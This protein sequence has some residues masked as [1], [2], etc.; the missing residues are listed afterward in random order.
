MPDYEILR[1]TA[2]LESLRDRWKSLWLDDPHATPFQ[3]PEWLVPWWHQFG[4]HELRVV[5]IAKAGRPLAILPLYIYPEPESGERRLLLPGVGTS[6]Y[7]DGI[8]SPLC[9]PAHVADALELLRHEGSWDVAHWQQLRIQ[10]RS[11]A[12][13]L[14]HRTSRRRRGASHRFSP[15]V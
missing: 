12:L 11:T 4:Q 8:F 3:F 2:Q 6:D 13:W 1:T 5:T 15:R 7:L 9:K 10:S 14:L